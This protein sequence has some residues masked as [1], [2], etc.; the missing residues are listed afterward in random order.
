MPIGALHKAVHSV[1]QFNSRCQVLTD[2]FT[3]RFIIHIHAVFKY[4]I[5][6]PYSLSY[7]LFKDI[8]NL[9]THFIYSFTYSFHIYLV[10]YQ[11][12]EIRIESENKPII[13]PFSLSI[14]VLGQVVVF[15]RTLSLQSSSCRLLDPLGGRNRK[16]TQP[17]PLFL[18]NPNL[19]PPFLYPF[20]QKRVCSTNELPKTTFGLLKS[21]LSVRPCLAF[22]SILISH[23]L[24][25]GLQFFISIRPCLA[26]NPIFI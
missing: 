25:F 8:L 20:Y 24:I 26:F 13:Y 15:T 16:Q 7:H 10:N 17:K 22:H 19:S 21:H 1:Y 2:S 4:H 14:P 18:A 5:S 23:F 6:I 12:L 11:I 3:I 9:C